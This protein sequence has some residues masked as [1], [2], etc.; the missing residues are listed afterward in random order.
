MQMV[1]DGCAWY[2][3]HFDNTLAYAEAE[4]EA[5][6][7]AGNGL[8]VA[9]GRDPPWLVGRWFLV[10][11]CCF[12]PIRACD[13]LNGILTVVKRGF[14]RGKTG[15]SPRR[16]IRLVR[17]KPALPFRPLPNVRPCR[18][19]SMKSM[20]GSEL[21]RSDERR[22]ARRLAPPHFPFYADNPPFKLPE[23]GRRVTRARIPF[24]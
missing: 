22:M 9:R 2:Y 17:S 3:K 15:F 19:S 5:R 4:R 7:W 1:R 13:G 14:V 23:H 8:A 24:R 11:W 16:N 12:A 6:A 21:P 18:S 20:N 10:G